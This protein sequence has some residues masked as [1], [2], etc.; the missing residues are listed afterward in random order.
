MKEKGKN[1]FVP[2]LQDRIKLAIDLIA[3][4]I[5]TAEI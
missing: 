4:A 1:C 5:A 3:N 2:I